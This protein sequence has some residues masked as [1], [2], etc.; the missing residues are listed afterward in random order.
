MKQ[1][2]DTLKVVLSQARIYIMVWRIN[3]SV[4]ETLTLMDTWWHIII[5]MH[6]EELSKVQVELDAE[7]G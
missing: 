6:C 7:D 2:N 5:L 1:N 3:L 4:Q